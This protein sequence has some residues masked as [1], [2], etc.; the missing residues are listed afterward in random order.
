[1]LPWFKPKPKAAPELTVQEIRRGREH[2][3]IARLRNLDA[4]QKELNQA[5]AAFR[6]KHMVFT[7]RGLAWLASDPAA[8]AGLNAELSEMQSRSYIVNQDRNAIVVELARLSSE[9]E[10]EMTHAS[11]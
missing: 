10:Y 5:E 8:L 3:L 7:G 6:S 9:R 4:E 1:M 2:C 11:H